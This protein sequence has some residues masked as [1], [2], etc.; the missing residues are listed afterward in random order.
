VITPGRLTGDLQLRVADVATGAQ[1]DET[2]PSTAGGAALMADFTINSVPTQ[3]NAIAQVGPLGPYG[4]LNQI[5]FAASD[6]SGPGGRVIGEIM[7]LEENTLGVQLAGPGGW[8][9]PIGFNAGIP[10]LGLS[11]PAPSWQDQV[12]VGAAAVTPA[13][14]PAIDLNRFV[15]PGA[16]GLPR[17][18]TTGQEFV[19]FSWVGAGTIF[20]TKF[21]RGHQRRVL[22]GPG[23]AGFVIDQAFPRAR[24]QQP[25]AYAGNPLINLAGFAVG[26]FTPAGATALAAD[27]M[28]TANLMVNP[29]DPTGAAI[30]GRLIVWSLLSGPITISAGAAPQPPAATLVQ[31]GLTPGTARV[32]GTDSIHPN[33]QVTGN[34]PV[35]AVRLRGIAAAP[36]RVPAGVLTS[37]VTVNA[38]PGGRTVQWVVD[39]PA[40]SAGV[41]V[42]PNPP[43]PA[44]AAGATVTR[45]AGFTGRVTVTATDSV[46]PAA[47]AT[48]IVQFL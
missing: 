42:A 34:V 31:A 16:P 47:R 12:T 48:V 10:V 6:P 29:Q 4:S 39:G 17:S 27:G 5:G 41:T 14:N 9:A 7:S 22:V 21:D 24:L 23:A 13:G 1:F 11:V 28:A 20:S 25:E 15:G 33:R 37:V 19:Y 46:I 32:K 35:V 43:M 3:V 8:N 36:A 2:T 30:P 44:P 38:N 40:M 18:L 45:P 26:G